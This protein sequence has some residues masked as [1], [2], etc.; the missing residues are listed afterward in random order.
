MRQLS[1]FKGRKQ[2]GVRPPPALEFNSHVVIADL[3][4]RWMNPGW[5]FTHIPSGEH[6]DHRANSKGQRYSPAG[7]RLKRM[8]LIP[9][10]PD[11][12]FAGPGKRVVWLELK[13]EKLGR[14]SDAQEDIGTHLKAC[15]FDFLITTDVGE[16]VRWLVSLGILRGN[17]EVQ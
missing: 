3:C 8:G 16:A 7:N 9:G 13:R 11:F 14:M 6:R 10:W 15:G 1:L 4:R 2:R 12:M 17:I 5:R